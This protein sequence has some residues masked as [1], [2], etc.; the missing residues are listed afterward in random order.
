MTEIEHYEFNLPNTPEVQKVLEDNG[1]D[2][3]DFDLN[4]DIIPFDYQIM[5]ETVN[6]II[7]RDEFGREEYGT[8]TVCLA[9]LDSDGNELT[10]PLI[11]LI[12]THKS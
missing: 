2:L 10:D 9:Y 8:E 7:N 6:M 5:D 1:Y 3:A 12:E 4:E 11:K